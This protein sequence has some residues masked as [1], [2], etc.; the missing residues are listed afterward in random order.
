MIDDLTPQ[1]ERVFGHAWL[2]PELFDCL[3]GITPTHFAMLFGI[4]DVWAHTPERG[5][6]SPRFSMSV[7]RTLHY[8]EHP[9]VF[10]L[11]VA[12]HPLWRREGV[13]TTQQAERLKRVVLAALAMVALEWSD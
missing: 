2:L 4:P 6:S 1:E 12:S 3:C 10:Y 5:L 7:G 13:H 11:W 9:D 8:V